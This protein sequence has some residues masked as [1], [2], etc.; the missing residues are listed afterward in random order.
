MRLTGFQVKNFKSILD[1]REIKIDP[2]VT[3]LMGM[4]ESGKSSVMQALWKFR[5][6]SK[7]KFDPLYDLPAQHFTAMRDKDPEVVYLSFSLEKKDFDALKKAFPDL[8]NPP[9][10]FKIRSTYKGVNTVEMECDYPNWGYANVFAEVGKMLSDLEKWLKTG[11]PAPEATVISAA[12][13]AL[14]A[15]DAAGKPDVRAINIPKPILQTAIDSLVAVK[16]AGLVDDAKALSEKLKPFTTAEA[17]RAKLKKWLDDNIP[18]FIYFDDYGR[19]RTRINLKDYHQRV[20]NPP[21][22]PEEATLL[23]SQIALF[24]WAELKT[25]ELEKL[26][27]PKAGNE[28]QE[29]VERRKAERRRLCESSSFKLSDDWEKW[30]DSSGHRMIFVPD[31][32][33]ITLNIADEI[34]PW[35]IPFGERSRG[36]QWFFSFYLTFLVEAGK[37][38]QGAILLLDEP[39]LHL[40]L[41]RQLKL[42]KFFQELSK[43]NQIIYSSHSPFMIDPDHVDNIRTVYKEEEP[44]APPPPGLPARMIKK[45]ERKPRYSR[46]S[47]TSEPEGDRDTI[48]PMQY[49]GAYLLSQTLFMGKRTLI[50]EGI[51]DYWLLKTLSNLLLDAKDGGLHPDTV[52]IWAGGTKNLMPLASIMSSREHGVGENRLAVLLDS[53]KTGTDKA[54]KLVEMMAHGNDSVLLIGALL[55]RKNAEIEDLLEVKELLAAV[56]AAGHKI[57]AA[58][59]PN[60]GESNCEFIER[61]YKVGAF[62]VEF[63]KAEKAN[64]ILKLVDSWRDKSGKPDDKTLERAKGLCKDINERFEKL[65]AKP[66]R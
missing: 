18:H 9:T 16:T 19:L 36:F 5:N 45:K 26:G 6:V 35:E 10:E 12:K 55:N 54:S 56:K 40:H 41:A 66:V 23:R 48:L 63:E 42:L 39:G 62:G 59:T 37:S 15:L 30:W 65:L 4:N 22:Q 3:C 57:P 7:T 31:G 1:S 47:L 17:E 53:D 46:V 51:T 64:V 50:V 32:D 24:Q 38:H 21:Q 33:D 29:Q 44:D 34:N 25:D 14:E 43:D 11:G 8:T 20:A 60:A 27:A 49:A 28:T 61:V 58:V 13:T 52:V 2:N